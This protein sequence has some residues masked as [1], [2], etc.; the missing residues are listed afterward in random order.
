MTK[1]IWPKDTVKD[2]VFLGVTKK[3]VK[4]EHLIAFYFFQLW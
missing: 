3:S 1:A 2:C 4:V